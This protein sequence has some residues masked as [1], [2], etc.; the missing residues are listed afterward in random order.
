[1]AFAN[2]EIPEEVAQK[3]TIGGR[4]VGACREAVHISHEARLLKSVAEDAIEDSV[5]AA[6]RAIKS[7]KRRVEDLGDLKDEAVRRVKRQPLQAL[8]AVFGVGITL[9]LAVGRIACRP[10]R[11]G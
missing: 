8:A 5:Y 7:V 9:G 11:H 1:M 10:G 3:T 6:K 2:V 4:V